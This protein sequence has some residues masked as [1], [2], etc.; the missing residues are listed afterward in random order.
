MNTGEKNIKGRVI[1]QGPR[2]G[3]YIIGPSGKKLYKFTLQHRFTNILPIEYVNTGDGN[4][5]SG[6]KNIRYHKNIFK[7]SRGK[8]TLMPNGIRKVYNVMYNKGLRNINGNIAYVHEQNGKKKYLVKNV[9]VPKLNKQN[10]T[11]TEYIKKILSDA[12]FNYEVKVLDGI[13]ATKNYYAKKHRNLTNSEFKNQITKS[14]GA[15]HINKSGIPRTEYLS[16]MFTQIEEA[17]RIIKGKILFRKM[18]KQD[19]IREFDQMVGG[20]PCIENLVQALTDIALGESGWK[21]KNTSKLLKI[22]NGVLNANSYRMLKNEILAPY[23]G[24]VYKNLPNAK[25]ITFKEENFWKLVKNKNVYAININNP[26]ILKYNRLMNVP[27]ARS[28]SIYA[29]E[30]YGNLNRPN[31]YNVLAKAIKKVRTL[32]GVR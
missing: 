16:S 21:G 14:I 22:Q 1:Y 32:R 24:E 10:Y 29:F 2:G 23:I 6:Y 25:K 15:C 26:Y 11:G 9:Y 20:R 8:Y 19:F 7:N 17:C 4:I 27:S 28:A 30:N 31:K 3:K 18:T 13:L 5:K 12:S